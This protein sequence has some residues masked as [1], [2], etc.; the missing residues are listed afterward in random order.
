MAFTYEYPH[1][2][3][4][5]D[6]VLF[7]TSS[8]NKSV[9]LIKRRNAPFKDR[10][11]LPGGYVDMTESVIDAAKRELSEETGANISSL[12]F[13][14]Y[15]DDVKRDPR[16]RTLSLAFLAKTDKSSLEI[17]ASDDASE[18]RWYPLESLP[19]LAFDHMLIID[20]AIKKLEG[21]V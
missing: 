3:V 1:M 14:G 6:V 16:E 8:Q 11:A 19:E 12:D 2:A 5:V 20:A 10:W 9:L 7:D 4:T 21:R 13:L 17:K 18:V 15:F